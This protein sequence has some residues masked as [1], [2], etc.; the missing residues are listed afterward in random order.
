MKIAILS[1]SVALSA[2]SF[3]NAA[4]GAYG[5][6]GGLNYT[7][8][9][10]CVSGYTCVYSNDWYSQCVPGAASTA[11]TKSSSST[12]A[13]SS[14][15]TS[16]TKTSSS[17]VKPSSTSSSSGS[18]T[19]G[20]SSGM[21]GYAALGGT[22]GGEGGTTTRVS[23]LAA[24]QAAVAGDAKKIVIL[25]TSLTGA[26]IVKPGSN[27][28]ILGATPGITLT[29]IGIRIIKVSNVIVRNLVI[30]KV[31]ADT[32]DAIGIQEASKVWINHVD[33]S[34]DRDHDKDY[35]DGLCDITH[36]STYVTVSWSKLH[37]HWKSMLIG[38]SDSNGSEDKAIT[39]TVHNN[40]W[41]NLNSRGPSFRFGTGHI[42]NN[43]YLNMNDGINTR[44]EAQLLVQNNVWEGT[45]SSALYST[46]G[47]F[48]Y[49]SGNDF[50]TCSSG[51]TALS[52]SLS[53]VPYQY[54]LTATSSVKSTVVAGAGANLSF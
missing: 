4:V 47:G 27:T 8:E 31:L 44:V 51:N 32:G 2:V 28:S 9:T 54:T 46:D 22:T 12:K 18:G 33:L 20:T 24:L 50:G 30:K 29:G 13:S 5:Q 39:V 43:Y 49:A 26:A 6:C 7:G 19:T 52:G 10:T 38:H 15:K 35:Y 37:D 53:S 1:L 11:S 45:C 21:V 40:Y 23:T 25:T 3:V 14:T 36:G 42:F 34:S 16:S 17:S 48:A 41:S